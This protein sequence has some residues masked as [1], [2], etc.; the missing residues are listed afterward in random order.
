LL[1]RKPIAKSFFKKQT[2]M[3]GLE[4]Q[5]FSPTWQEAWQHPGRHGAGEKKNVQHP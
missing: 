3:A 1:G 5:I 2:L 4:F